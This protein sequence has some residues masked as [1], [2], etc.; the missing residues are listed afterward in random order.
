MALA[1]G[2]RLWYK[3]FDNSFLFAVDK[4][5]IADSLEGEFG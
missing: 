3:Q 4:K 1:I 2:W 5:R